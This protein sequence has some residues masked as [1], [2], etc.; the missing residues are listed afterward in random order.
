[1]TPRVYGGTTSGKFPTV[2][3]GA[4][5]GGRSVVGPGGS[6]HWTGGVHPPDWSQLLLGLRG[7]PTTL[8]FPRSRHRRTPFS[9]LSSPSSLPRLCLRRDPASDQVGVGVQPLRPAVVVPL[10]VPEGHRGPP[11]DK[12]VPRVCGQLTYVDVSSVSVPTTRSEK[13]SSGV[14]SVPFSYFNLVLPRT[15]GKPPPRPSRGSLFVLRPGPGALVSGPTMQTS[16]VKTEEG[17]QVKGR[18]LLWSGKVDAAPRFLL[19]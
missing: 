5:G 4:S 13:R 8:Y 6:R 1:M 18:D 2:E 12:E 16:G 14:V 10:L 11:R 15:N 3:S 9:F 7:L 19:S 17:I